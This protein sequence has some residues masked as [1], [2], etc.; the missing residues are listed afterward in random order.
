MMRPDQIAKID[1]LVERLAD[2]FIVEADP[3]NWTAGGKL[4]CD[5]SKQERGDRHWDRKGAVGTATVLNHAIN[6]SR[7]YRERAAMSP[8]GALPADEEA[9]LDETIRK[10]AQ[11]AESAE[12]RAEKHAAA[13]VKR[14]MERST[15]ATSGRT[16]KP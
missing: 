16:R 9:E 3:E 7:H 6:L 13:A 10:A 14:A 15:K 11:R 4:P 8:G 1:D 5:M 12:Q 2:V